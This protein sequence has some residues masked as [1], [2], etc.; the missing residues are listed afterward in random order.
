MSDTG[1]P[2]EG[3]GIAAATSA[4]E[5]ILAGDDPAN[6]EVE[7]GATEGPAIDDEAEAQATQSED[8]TPTDE[9]GAE[10]EEATANDD[11]AE[12][13]EAPEE[14]LV[15]VKID[16]ETMQIPVSEAAR[17]YQRQADYSRHMAA[18]K[19]QSQQVE[20]AQVH[21]AQLLTALE[22]RLTQPQQIL[23]QEPD[24]ERLY[25]EDPL[26]YVRLKD[27]WRDQQEQLQA[28]QAENQR[29]AFMQEQQRAQQLQARVQQ[30]REELFEQKPE[31][32][33]K[34]KWDARRQQLRSY[35]ES[36]GFSQEQISQVY[37]PQLVLLL[38]KALERD[39]LM[40]RKLQPVK[41]NS[42][43]P[44]RAGAPQAMQ[45]RKHSDLSK[46]KM[47]LSRTGSVKDAAAIFESLI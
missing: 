9:E 30:G 3:N 17:G 12:E 41:S 38:D 2:V 36:L 20:A 24:W 8:E 32:R 40:S 1:T 47:R 13:A 37:V 14:M 29:I 5:K 28:V 4:F 27:V 33:D 23:P 42:P 21:Y 11:D 19:E 22:Q 46:A 34:A 39:E 25:A 10:D 16:G 6:Q 26:E 44:A 18:L 45:T 15:T 31:W 7:A 43:K 35:A